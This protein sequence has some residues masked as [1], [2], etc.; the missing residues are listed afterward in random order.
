MPDLTLRQKRSLARRY[1]QIKD[2]G[3]VGELFDEYGVSKPT[4]LKIA[5][6]FAPR[7]KKAPAGQGG[8]RDSKEAAQSL[9]GE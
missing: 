1:W 9:T 5:R 8:G 3:T 6:E 7:N 2:L 4:G